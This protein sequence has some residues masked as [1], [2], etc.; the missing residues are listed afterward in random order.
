[1]PFTFPLTPST[2]ALPVI[3]SHAVNERTHCNDSRVC[4]FA[5]EPR[6]GECSLCRSTQ[7]AERVQN[8]KPKPVGAS[9]TVRSQRSARTHACTHSRKHT[10]VH[11]CD[12]LLSPSAKLWLCSPPSALRHGSACGCDARRYRLNCRRQLGRKH[13]LA[14]SMIRQLSSAVSLP[15]AVRSAN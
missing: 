6:Y 12:A 10:H 2:D 4:L 1:M 7:S 13:S 11:R 5:E 15:A 9:G 3:V 8:A 14:G